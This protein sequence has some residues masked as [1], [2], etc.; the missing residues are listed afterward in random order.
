MS[1]F[2]T[3]FL[4]PSILFSLLMTLIFGGL[5]I[6]LALRAGLIDVPGSAPHKRHASPTP[7]AGGLTLGFALLVSAAY[8][9]F[10]TDPEIRAIFISGM[11]VLLLALVDDFKGIPPGAKLLGQALAVIVLIRLGVYIR[12]FESPGFFVNG[13]GGV[14]VWLDWLLTAL[15]IIGITNAF[16]FVDS[17]DGLAVALAGLAAAFFM[18][19]TFDSNQPLLSQ[20]NALLV[21]VCIGL[22]FFNAPPARM[23]LGDAGAQ[24]LGFWLACLAIVYTPKGYF[25]TSSWFVPI[26]ILGVP[27]F[28]TALVVFSRLRR[29]RPFYQSSLDHTY[30][31]LVAM[32]ME[33]NRAVVTMH[34]SSLALGCLAFIALDKPPLLA[35]LIFIV[36]LLFGT[37]GIFYLDRRKCWP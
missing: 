3:T 21:G 30:H 26:L 10:L 33:P 34:L 35:N 16:N 8:Y 37:V 15:W 23:F 25:Q 32:G 4:F 9:P 2:F 17:M 14:Y 12:I 11:I 19:V 1:A 20:Q 27:I 31:R 36:V 6:P 7:L 18:L 13:Q 24:T 29:G 5:S 22:Y 28:D